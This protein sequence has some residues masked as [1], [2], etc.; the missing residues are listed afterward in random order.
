MST[1]KHRANDKDRTSALLRVDVP[2]VALPNRE[3]RQSSIVMFAQS[4]RVTVLLP[5]P[6]AAYRVADTVSSTTPVKHA[7][8][9]TGVSS[10]AHSIPKPQFS[11]VQVEATFD[12]NTAVN[13]ELAIDTE[14]GDAALM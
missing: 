7:D 4:V 9:E 3:K 2:S 6:D 1:S 11:M 5:A 10:R 14:Y 8:M 13:P 12:I